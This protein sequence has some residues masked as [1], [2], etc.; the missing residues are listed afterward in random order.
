MLMKDTLL[1]IIRHT[2]TTAGGSLIAKGVLT[3]NTL[4]ESVGALVT[5]IGVVWSIVSKKQQDK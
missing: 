4:D 2:L 3:T 1:G 5:L